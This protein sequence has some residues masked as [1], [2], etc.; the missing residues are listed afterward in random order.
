MI[1]IPLLVVC[2]IIILIGIVMGK[3]H[4]ESTKTML[5][6]LLQISDSTISPLLQFIVVVFVIVT[7]LSLSY[8]FL[9]YI[10]DRLVTRF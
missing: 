6:E 9:N 10:I 3:I 4:G 5:K 1:F 8:L 2:S 7:F